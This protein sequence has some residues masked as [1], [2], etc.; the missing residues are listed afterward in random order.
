MSC[1]ELRPHVALKGCARQVQTSTKYLV[2]IDTEINSRT[3]SD[4]TQELTHTSVDIN[5]V[6]DRHVNLFYIPLVPAF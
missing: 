6:P 3:E 2:L 1:G 5:F 4:P